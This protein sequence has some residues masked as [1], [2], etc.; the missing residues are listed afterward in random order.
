M[1]SP[2]AVTAAMAFGL[3]LRLA[4]ACWNGL[5]GPSFG[6]DADAEYFHNFAL[7]VARDAIPAGA[8]IDFSIAYFLGYVYRL[9]GE[10]LL[11][12]SLI[13][14]GVWLVSAVVL[15]R[16]M[17]LL[18]VGPIQA[19][20]GM[21]IYAVLPSSVLWTS[22]TLRE[23]YQL[24]CVNVIFHGALRIVSA[25]PGRNWL[26]LVTGAAVGA[27]LHLALVIF[28]CYAIIVAAVTE[29]W[30]AARSRAVRFVLAGLAVVITVWIGY[31]VVNT[32]YSYG[33][34]ASPDVAIEK[35]HESGLRIASRTNYKADIPIHRVTELIADGPIALFQYLFEPMP[36][37]LNAPI[38]LGFAAENVVRAVLIGMMVASL[39]RLGGQQR[40]LLL[41]AM[42]SYFCL[43]QVW[44]L[45][46]FNWGTAARHHVPA[47]GLLIAAAFSYSAGT[48]DAA[49]EPAA[50]PSRPATVA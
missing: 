34:N 48:V 50:V 1:T 44:A 27:F 33:L 15:R 36:W 32:L 40:M 23:P 4:V 2:R 3:A 46:T 11:V 43:E 22:V 5:A 9:T 17:Q 41:F 47:L 35:F 24:L 18:V 8:T 19:A 39:W 28:A 14:C 45:G 21:L 38:D 26:L 7:L 16:T 13:S 30:R 20:A 25:R 31:T 29:I 42:A 37:R 12:G 10:S 6:A 49:V